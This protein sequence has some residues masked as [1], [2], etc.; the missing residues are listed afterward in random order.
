MSRRRSR[1]PLSTWT[2]QQGGRETGRVHYT[3]APAEAS[4]DREL[5]L[6][7]QFGN[8]FVAPA[9][10]CNTFTFYKQSAESEDVLCR[11]GALFIARAQNWLNLCLRP[12]KNLR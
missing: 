4:Y 8:V 6:A 7:L 11:S 1:R 10:T 2:R 5:S 12:F 9:H 3:R